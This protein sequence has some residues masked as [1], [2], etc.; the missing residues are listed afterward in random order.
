TFEA[1]LLESPIQR[2][3]V[4]ANSADHAT[5]RWL[6]ARCPI[7]PAD[8]APLRDDAQ[9]VLDQPAGVVFGTADDA[10]VVRLFL[11]RHADLAEGIQATGTRRPGRLLD[12]RLHVGK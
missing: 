9:A 5:L 11:L 4:G 7:R 8:T 12:E 6:G 3:L 1:M 10:H 2:R